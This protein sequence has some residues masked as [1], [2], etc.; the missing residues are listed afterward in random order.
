MGAQIE[1]FGNLIKAKD[2]IMER[3]VQVNL[4]PEKR[5]TLVNA[6]TKRLREEID[7]VKK[8]WTLSPQV[9]L[10]KEKERLE[11]EIQ[12]LNDTYAF[13]LDRK[14]PLTEDYERVS[15]SVE[16][17]ELME[18]RRQL[19][20]SDIPAR[21]VWQAAEKGE[22][23]F[24]TDELR[25]KPTFD[26]ESKFWGRLDEAGNGILHLAAAHGKKPVVQFLLANGADPVQLDSGGYTPLHWAAKAGYVDIIQELLNAKVDP[27]ISGYRGRTSLHQAT[28]SNQALMVRFLLKQGAKINVQAEGESKVTPLHEVASRGFLKAAEALLD[29]P[30][31]DVNLTDKRNHAPLYY[32]VSQGFLEIAAL[33]VSHPSWK[34]PTDANDPNHV[35]RLM[36]IEP[37]QNKAEIQGLLKGLPK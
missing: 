28:A 37:T 8:C 1:S 22:V 15:N 31:L 33:I 9:D 20:A 17:R 35:D 11:G 18:Q 12:Q 32:A 10:K 13:M 21:T 30:S 14:V 24:F 2:A 7:K 5:T 27:N 34:C 36:Q 19:R 16:F 26:K 29:N 4:T 23:S 3:G 6:E 25:K